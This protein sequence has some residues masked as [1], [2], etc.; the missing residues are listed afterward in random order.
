MKQRILSRHGHLSN[1]AAAA[2]A[3]EI[4]TEKLEDLFLGHLSAD[5]NSPDLAEEVMRS[6][7]MGAGIQHVRV[8]RAHPDEPSITLSWD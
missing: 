4:A 3:V 5:C 1:S 7:L 8:H 6:T 2:L